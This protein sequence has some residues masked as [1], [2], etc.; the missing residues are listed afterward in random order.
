MVILGNKADKFFF[1]ALGLGFISVSIAML[2]V[3]PEWSPYHFGRLG[4]GF[5]LI[6]LASG[7][8]LLYAGMFGLMTSNVTEVTAHNYNMKIAWGVFIFLALLLAFAVWSAFY[9]IPEAVDQ[10]PVFID[11][12]AVGFGMLILMITMY[13]YAMTWRYFLRLER[14]AQP[15]KVLLKDLE[16]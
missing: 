3:L 13:F 9:V 8:V 11:W 4:C 7:T 10:E 16:G 2:G 14:L 5:F 1:I 15:M 12:L 6:Q